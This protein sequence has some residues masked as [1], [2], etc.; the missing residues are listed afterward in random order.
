M[1]ISAQRSA[2]R[3]PRCCGAASIARMSLAH[4]STPARTAHPFAA[5]SSW[6]NLGTSLLRCGVSRRCCGRAHADLTIR[7]RSGNKSTICWNHPTARSRG[8]AR[9]AISCCSGLGIV[10]ITCAY[11]SPGHNVSSSAACDARTAAFGWTLRV[12][13]A[14]HDELWA[15][16][17][18]FTD[19][20]SGERTIRNLN[21]SEKLGRRERDAARGGGGLSADDDSDW[22]GAVQADDPLHLVL[23]PAG[24]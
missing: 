5:L 12:R 20:E 3:V 8:Q 18:L 14:V 19:V 11:S 4:V 10:H 2:I 17:C 24:S 9:N 21:S 16:A 7:G 6:S 13:E 22:G 23:G 15:Q 1:A